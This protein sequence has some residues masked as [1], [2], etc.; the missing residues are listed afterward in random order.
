MLTSPEWKMDIPE[1]M[2]RNNIAHFIN[3]GIEENSTPSSEE[4]CLQAEG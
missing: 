1:I 2:D 4:E 3:P